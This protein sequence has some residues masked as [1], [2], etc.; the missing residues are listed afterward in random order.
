MYVA[1]ADLELTV[2]TRLALNS[3]RSICLPNAGIKGMCY[4]AWLVSYNTCFM[5]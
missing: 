5:G 2:L 3:Q 4:N 1:L